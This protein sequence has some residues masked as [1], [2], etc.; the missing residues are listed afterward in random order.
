MVNLLP[1][2]AQIEQARNSPYF[3]DDDPR[4]SFINEMRRHGFTPPAEL[5]IGDIQRIPS[6]QD[7]NPR[8]ASGWYIYNE[9]DDLQNIGNQIGVGTYGS[10]KGDPEKVTWSSKS[11]NSMNIQERLRYNAQIEAAKVKRENELIRRNNDAA[12][13]SFEEWSTSPQAPNDHPYLIRKQVP[14]FDG[15][16]QVTYKDQPAIAIPV[17][18]KDVMTSL[19]YI[20]PD[21]TKR[22]K[23][24]G[25]TKGCYYKING[26]LQNTVYIA[27]GY[28]TAASI[29]MA[30][31]ATVYIAFSA[32]NIYETTAQAK[33]DYPHAKIIIA[34]DDDRF[35]DS[36]NA[37]RTKSEQAAIGLGVDVVF[38]EFKSLES[39]P[40]D[41]ND[42]HCLEGLDA[43]KALLIKAEKPKA[44]KK[45]EADN[46]NDSG[47]AASDSLLRPSGILGEIVAYYTATAGNEQPLFAVQCAIATCSVLLARSFQ[48]SRS[49]RTS[50]FI[51]NIGKSG[52]GK[53][54]AKKVM[55]NIIDAVGEGHV[56]AGDGYTSASG[57][58]AALMSKPRHVTV[59]DEFSKHLQASQ[60]KGNSHLMESNTQMMQAIGR[61]DGVMRPRNFSTIGLTKERQKEMAEMKVIN[62]AITLLAMSTPDD[63][64]STL[65][66]SSVKDGF[67]NRFIICVS[68]AERA[69]REHKEALEV[70]QSIIDWHN[71]IAARKATQQETPFDA[72]PMQ[73][74]SFTVDAMLLQHEFQQFC[75]DTANSL[76]RY[77][78]AELSG[79]ANEMA[80]RLSLIHAL[81]RDPMASTINEDDMR[82]SIGWVKFNMIRLIDKLK[83]SIA[84]SEYEGWKKECL[85]KFRQAGENGLPLSALHKTAPF[86]K[87]RKRDLEE[88]LKALEEGELI[89]KESRSESG[90]GR[91]S[92]Y[93]FAI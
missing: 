39:K 15:V 5:A 25:M 12:M 40:V 8:S 2:A 81:S 60:N 92:I 61:L 4:Q 50:L 14:A 10:W 73:T 89:F 23:S 57:V 49:N 48:T 31:S 59:I 35:S 27:E 7:T 69:I 21:G 6:P 22:F 87:L 1:F 64:F 68:D 20:L 38:P 55:E 76:E 52:T 24:G 16:K 75:I 53:E 86:S 45:K 17:L 37:G 19:Q 74:L 32:G 80:M 82:W 34:S 83:V 46:N 9:F 62:P 44:Y 65:D 11:S 13:S 3:I 43:V 91:P 42:L 67:L 47:N 28:A 41:F 71:H 58:L 54:H 93:Y 70:P 84:G 85:E 72:P 33:A 77:G 30:T 51:L 18:K 88:V 78:M 79:R 66:V 63:L 56:I 29:A 26:S 90:R 36:I